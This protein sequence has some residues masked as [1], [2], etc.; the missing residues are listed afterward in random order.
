MQAWTMW[1]KECRYLFGIPHKTQRSPSFFWAWSWPPFSEWINANRWG[2]GVGVGTARYMSNPLHVRGHTCIGVGGRAVMIFEKS[3]NRNIKIK[4]GDLGL[5]PAEWLFIRF[6]NQ[7]PRSKVPMEDPTEGYLIFDS[8]IFVCFEN[9]FTYFFIR[10]FH[11]PDLG[12]SVDVPNTYI[13]ACTHANSVA[14]PA[15]RPPVSTQGVAMH[16]ML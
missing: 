4:N 6:V 9:Q 15:Q 3:E 1:L 13:F 10:Y 11:R 12:F 2:H 14:C 16:F 5:A 8:W 7:W